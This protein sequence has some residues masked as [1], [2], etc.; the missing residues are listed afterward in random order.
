VHGTEKVPRAPSGE[1]P[2]LPA[3][4]KRSFGAILLVVFLIAG[5]LAAALLLIQVQSESSVPCRLRTLPAAT[6]LADR[7]GLVK[8]AR[9]SKGTKVGKGALL[10]ALR[11]TAAEKRAAE[12][13]E[14]LAK[15]RVTLRR[16]LLARSAGRVKALHRRIVKLSK[17]LG[18]SWRCRGPKCKELVEGLREQ[19]AEGRAECQY[20]AKPP[21]VEAANDLAS[22]IVD[23]E[24]QVRLLSEDVLVRS[25]E[26]GL[27]TSAAAAGAGVTKGQVLA[28][29][30]EAER[31][32]VGTGLAA[33][34]P[35]DKDLRPHVLVRAAG[36]EERL[37]ADLG[38][39]KGGRLT[40]HAKAEV[41]A[42]DLGVCRVQLTLARESLGRSLLRKF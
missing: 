3:A 19:I 33:D 26:R 32:V 25:P 17:R 40:L 34:T 37:L 27:L 18:D 4:P 39:Q 1:T 29:L 28:E 13:E 23:K 35:L 30:I 20:C 12:L 6:V 8:T 11:D 42:I 21:T 2:S 9:A 5:A 38:D 36:K 24:K 22:R 14:E 16:M 10:F 41:A 15:N 7:D 31:L